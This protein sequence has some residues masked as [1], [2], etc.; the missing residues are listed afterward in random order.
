MS[1]TPVQ[2]VRAL[3]RALLE[4]QLL[5]RRRKLPVLEAI[6]RLVGLQAQVPIDPYVGLWSRL[7]GFRPESLGA[8]LQD[9][10]AVRTAV[11]RATLHLVTAPDCL[12][13][14]AVVQ[15]M[16][17]RA[18]RS[19]TFAKQLDG[20]D[21][22]ALLAEGRARLEDAPRTRLELSRLLRER[23]PDHDEASLAYAVS[24]IVP[25]VQVPPRGVWGKTGRATWTT[26]ASWLGAEPAHDRDPDELVLR[27]LAAFGPATPADAQS[28][29]GVTGMR[30]VF[31]RL[32]PRLRVVRD[33]RGRELFDLP[34]AP[35]P[36]P[37]APA[38]VRFLPQ[39]DN[40]LLA[41]KDRTR[42]V[43]AGVR[44]WAEVGWGSV[45]VD[46]FLAARWRLDREQDVA[47]LRV[48]PLQTLRRAESAEVAEEGE[49]LMR[50]LAE[51]ATTHDLRLSAPA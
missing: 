9:R 7:Q 27:Y 42:I 14:K 5:L 50:L 37:D 49:R 40:A 11:M 4:R 6:D 24:Y 35:L 44:Q 41:H 1:S 3:N 36:G 16:L 47:T 30:A 33:D 22:D 46:G 43:P 15:R 32:R 45:L 51:N 8:A 20:V 13:M 48:E 26:V 25:L 10:R 17:E 23:W 12:A 18:F 28:W 2:S 21:L 34:G 38:P 39:F 31:D 29:S 19:S